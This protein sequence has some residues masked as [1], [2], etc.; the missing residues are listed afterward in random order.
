[1]DRARMQSDHNDFD[2]RRQTIINLSSEG[3]VV[4]SWEQA[5]QPRGQISIE[6][7]SA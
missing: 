2:D 1:M 3:I 5:V 4:I 6:K 7:I